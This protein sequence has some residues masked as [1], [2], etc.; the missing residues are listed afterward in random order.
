M[1]QSSIN[2]Q[3]VVSHKPSFTLKIMNKKTSLLKLSAACVATGLVIA[4]SVTAQTWNGGGADNNW[5]NA[6][7]WGG[8]APVA[9]NNLTFAGD[10]RLG[11]VNNFTAGTVFGN[12]TFAAGAEAFTLTGN[13]FA[14]ASTSTPV[15]ITNNSSNLQTLNLAVSVATT[16][17]FTT[18]G[19]GGDIA[20][21]SLATGSVVKLG[22]GT[23]TFGTSNYGSTT[24]IGTSGGADG[25]TIRFTGNKTNQGAITVFAGTFD[26]NGNT[27]SLGSGG[28]GL[29]LGGGA[30]GTSAQVA[31]G[32]GGTLNLTNANVTSAAST[33]GHSIS[34]GTINLVNAARSFTP[35]DGAAAVDL[36]ISSLIANGSGT[37]SLT[38]SGAGTMRLTNQ[39]TYT[40]VTRVTG[41]GLL[42]FTSV[43]DGGTASAIGASSSAAGN[44]QILNS[45]GIS[46][47]GGTASTDRLFQVGDSTNADTITVSANGSGAINF[48]NTGSLTYGTTNQIRTLVLSGTNTGANTLSAKIDNN[49]SSAVSLTKTGDGT[50]ILAGANN[51]YTGATTV[52]AGTLLVN[53]ASNG[54]SAF[55]VGNGATL[56]GSGTIAGNVTINSGGILSPGQ[57]AGLLT[58]GNLNLA[59][60]SFSG[61]EL[62][63]LGTRGVNYDAINV[64]GSL[65]Y[66]G[67][68]IIDVDMATIGLGDYALVNFTSQS[69]TFSAINFLQA[70]VDGTFDYSTGV[71]TLTAIPEPSTWALICVGLAALAFARRCRRVVG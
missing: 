64:T 31:L 52:S 7:N 45:S 49:G 70:G 35:T 50:W 12:I 19:S 69:G 61:F 38:K 43:A 11:P 63:S 51:T 46:Y 71:L 36:T 10:T 1:D 44:L 15:A 33:V 13:S 4:Q 25:G 14:A 37:G 53:G 23:L 41:G 57:S 6:A 59:N 21:G 58:V 54:T 47:L 65:T 16:R 24:T 56:G 28:V 32:T 18:N 60:G 22:E 27:T 62:F 17:T 39:N 48:T 5:T 34:G 3:R 8:T 20:V 30:A 55:T 26:L 42:E 29:A 67:S 9:T 2:L 68:L 66:G 40:G